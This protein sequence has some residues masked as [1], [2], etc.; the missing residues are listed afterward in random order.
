MDF[1]TILI[2]LSALSVSMIITVLLD[3]IKFDRVF[4]WIAKNLD[5][6]RKE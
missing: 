6:L 4:K 2:I 5:R 1:K 3:S